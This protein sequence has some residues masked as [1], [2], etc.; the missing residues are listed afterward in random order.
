MEKELMK[1]PSEYGAGLSPV[2]KRK[3]APEGGKKE[4][5]KEES[6]FLNRMWC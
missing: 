6:Y 4:R 3:E 2:K 5:W 1:K